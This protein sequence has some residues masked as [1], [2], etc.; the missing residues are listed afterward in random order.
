MATAQI[1]DEA[2]SEAR[3][4][5]EPLV[6]GGGPDRA[7]VML[8]DA[9]GRSDRFAEAHRGK[10]DELDATAVAAAMRDL[11]EIFDLV[12]RAGSYA[13]LRFAI[14]TQDPGRGALLQ[15]VRE[16]GAAIETT[17]LFFDLEWNELDDARADE[18][19][20]SDE[21]ERWRHHLR[22]LRRFRPHQLSEPEERVLT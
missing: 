5:L 8:D 12:G 15:Q 22:T 3:W 4:D 18:L 13:A 20:A 9:K 16:R 19:I 2:L 21:L 7:L 10:V 14:D 17:L 11:E 6:E 1:S